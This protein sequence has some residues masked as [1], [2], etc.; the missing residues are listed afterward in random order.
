MSFG[1]GGFGS[2][3]IACCKRVYLCCGLGLLV[4]DLVG[5]IY[6]AGFILCALLLLLLMR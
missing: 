4:V 2:P 1:F 6:C 3:L 5:W